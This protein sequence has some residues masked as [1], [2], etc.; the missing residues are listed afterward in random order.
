MLVPHNRESP[1]WSPRE[2]PVSGLAECRGKDEG[3]A[4]EMIDLYHGTT[5]AAAVRI[6]SAGFATL[7]PLRSVLENFCVSYVVSVDAVI[8]QLAQMNRFLVV[9]TER[10]EGVWFATTRTAG[11]RWA[12]RAPEWRWEA[13]WAVW[14]LRHGQSKLES[15]PDYSWCL[16]PAAS[17]WHLAQR[18]QDLPA[19][20]RV[21]VEPN[22]LADRDRSLVGSSSWESTPEVRIRFADLPTKTS[23][24]EVGERRV[25]FTDACGFLHLSIEE[26]TELVTSGEVPWPEP[27]RDIGEDAWW[28]ASSFVTWSRFDPVQW[29]EV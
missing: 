28:S 9:Q 7:P 4:L 6:V 5:E 10:S 18:W 12:D 17:A 23:D 29:L 21:E 19:V 14:M 22:A 2:I 25:E 26:L 15:T 20:I 11:L 13:L 3:G 27:A 24:I 8:D 16:D 1:T